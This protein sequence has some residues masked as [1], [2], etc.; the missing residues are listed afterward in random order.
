MPARRTRSILLALTAALLLAPA[1]AS[2]SFHLTKITE[3]FPGTAAVPDSAFVELQAYQAGQ[4]LLKDHDFKAYDAAGSVL[5]TFTIPA[6]PA[7]SQTQRTA[8]YSDS[9]PP[10]GVT[11]DSVFV[12]LGG[13]INPTGGAVCFETVDCVAWGSF[14]GGGLPSPAGAPVAPGGIPDG[15]SISR[16]IAP[17][18]AT[19][20][21][22]AD[23]SNV[24]AADF[25]LTA[26]PSPRPNS[27]SPPEHACAGG[28]P[29]TVIDRGPKKMT[30]KARATFRFS[31]PDAGVKFECRLDRKPFKRCSSPQVYKSLDAGKHSFSVRA[32]RA[33]T[34]DPS[35]ARY[36]WKVTKPKRG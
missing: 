34:A 22:G 24:S 10:D 4:N 23:D 18:C 26:D 30:T 14:A 5:E 29:K 33:G 3:V 7:S 12:D 32:I 15:I 21:E 31:S 20:L 35:P 9:S 16:S 6:N 1:G 2:A 13:R 25:G 11:P 28:A 36:S 19:L 17:G 27:T 8:L